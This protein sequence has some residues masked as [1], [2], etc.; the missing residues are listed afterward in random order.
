MGLLL[1]GEIYGVLLRWHT[2][3]TPWSAPSGSISTRCLQTHLRSPITSAQPQ[4]AVNPP[5]RETR[6]LTRSPSQGQNQTIHPRRTRAD[7]R[8]Y[9]TARTAGSNN[10]RPLAAGPGATRPRQRST[11]RA[12]AQTAWARSCSGPALGLFSTIPGRSRSGSSTP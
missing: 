5:C 9:M 1:M 7:S 11:G 2:A 4:P 8:S 12:Q 6:I 3:S 10:S